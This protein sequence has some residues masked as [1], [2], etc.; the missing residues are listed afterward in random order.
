M[1]R[2]RP[3]SSRSCRAAASARRGTSSARTRC[4]SSDV[5][6]EGWEVASDTGVTVALDTALDD[7]LR[8]EGQVLDLIHL[9][10]TKRKEAGLELT[11]RITVSLP[12]DLAHLLAH[13]DWIKSEVLAVAIET[14]GAG[15]EPTIAKA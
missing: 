5:G 9:L 15:G 3:A 6:R 4:W 8:L 1:L 7:E 12:D 10:N 14:D 13:A 2:W 11:D